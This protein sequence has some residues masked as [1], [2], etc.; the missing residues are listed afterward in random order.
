ML[1][2]SSK[3]YLKE[4]ICIAV[5]VCRGDVVYKERGIPQQGSCNNIKKKSINKAIGLNVFI[6]FALFIG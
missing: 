5:A 4:T 3:I 2:A 6:K 1:T